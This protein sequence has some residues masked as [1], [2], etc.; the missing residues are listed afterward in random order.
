M[1][2]FEKFK[3]QVQKQID[4]M[5]E[6][7]QILYIMDVD[8][9]KL[10]DKYLD[11][12][13]PGSNEL[14]RER[15]EYDCA[16]C[17]QF[18]RNFGHVVTIKA[19]KLVSI[20]DFTTTD[21]TFQPV[22]K[23]LAAFVKTGKIE[24]VF[25]TKENVIGTDSNLE[26]IAGNS[27]RWEHLY[28][29]LP[30]FLITKSSK[31]L[32]DLMGTSRDIRNVFKRSLDEITVE[33]LDTVLDLIS[34]N[35][36]Y[37]G[38]EWKSV[39]TQFLKLKKEYSKLQI[40]S[41]PREYYCW[42]KS[43]QVGPV[44]GKIRNH[45]IG[46]LLVDISEGMDIDEAVKRYEK[47]VAPTNYKRSNAIFTKK[48]VEQAESTLKEMG[49]ISALGRRYAHI[50]DITI[51]NVLFADKESTARMEGSVF[52]D[53]K[54]SVAINP[55][56]FD[57]VEEIPIA[58]FIANVLPR[59]TSI[60]AMMENSHIGNLVS[61][62]APIDKTSKSMFKW[63]NNFCWA[64]NGNITDS[65]KERVKAAG[66]KVDGVL[67]FSIQWNENQDNRNDFDAHCVEP[68]G[69]HI[70]Y[71]NKGNVHYSS[72]MLDVDIIQPEINQVA[73]ENIIY[74][75]LNKMP[76]GVY[77]FYVNTY[78][79]R[80]GKN[81]FRAEIEF[82]GQ[83]FSFDYPKETREGEN[84][85]VAKVM[86][87]KW[88]GFSIIQS[89][90]AGNAIVTSREEWGIKTNQFTPV[91]IC[92]YSPNYWDFQNGIGNRHYFFMLKGCTNETF[93]NGFFNEFLNNN[94]MEHKRVFEALGAKM[95]VQDS[96]NQLSGLGF[97][98]TQ[99]NHLICKLGG[100]VERVVKI[101][102]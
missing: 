58:D 17:R 82:N 36:L 1:A 14:Y 30:E 29:K 64:Y 5:I 72:G 54:E 16:C 2:N 32:G 4:K 41:N 51:Q 85:T 77:H 23:A 63:N 44:I 19:N 27:R 73:V 10:W 59:V 26:L 66:G 80:R 96:D 15:R 68:G 49:M 8:R 102:F 45:S 94:L 31:S 28:F 98:R 60:G 39:L 95:K 22:I 13:P 88:D 67:R 55:K 89:L 87:N 83:L 84:V 52:D 21:K 97:S 7:E 101:V 76:E 24:N 92:M 43:M 90:N 93:P 34:Q 75:N 69:R 3:E 38:E 71:G 100:T 62:I 25:M 48:M 35:S 20:W 50:D 81:G 99:R 40:N 86:Y 37:K 57:K 46:V 70:Y 9:D 11:S 47:I 61:L 78:S 91:S 12:F 74:T 56:T 65:M 53:L 33:S 18:I 6:G 42:D 79:N